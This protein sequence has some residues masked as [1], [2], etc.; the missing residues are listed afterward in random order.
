[1]LA[2][3]QLFIIS[4]PSGAGKT[5]LVKALL[6]LLPGLEVSVSYTTRPKR[7]SEQA[8]IDYNYVPIEHF[9]TMVKEGELLEY[10]EV[11]GNYYGTSAK[12]VEEQLLTGM[13]VI[14]EIDW[15][16]AQQVRKLVSDCVSIFI[17]PPSK[18]VLE[19]RLKGRGQDADNIIA[20]RMQAAVAEMS[21]YVEFDYLVVN[22]DF[23]MALND[24]SSLVKSQRLKVGRASKG[25]PVIMDLDEGA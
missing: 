21:H 6:D 8:G 23:G 11:F 1:M 25:L 22:D 13:D 17:L 3:G 9:Q 12:L 7:P 20:R 14:L 15:Q 18:E 24:L 5:S 19:K 16:G 2:K 4:A 10:A